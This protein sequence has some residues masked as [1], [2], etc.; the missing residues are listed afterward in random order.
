MTKLK[1]NIC[2]CASNKN[3]LC[4]RPYIDVGG[5]NAC[6]CC[7]TCCDSYVPKSNSPTNSSD[8][9]SPNAALEINCKAKNCVHN[10]SGKCHAGLVNIENG[11]NG[12]ECASFVEKGC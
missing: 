6:L 3:N 9:S 12:I 8:Y 1:C 5:T 7:E 10:Q 4:C 2:D 11:S